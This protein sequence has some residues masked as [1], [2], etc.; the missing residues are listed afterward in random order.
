MIKHHGLGFANS[1]PEAAPDLLKKKTKAVCGPA[2]NG[3]AYRW[4]VGALADY[5]AAT[6][7]LNLSG[8]KP[9]D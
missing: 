8:P 5:F 7:N 2:K 9:V 6:Q 3:P 1:R 4:H